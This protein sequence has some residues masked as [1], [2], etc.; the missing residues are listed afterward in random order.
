MRRQERLVVACA[1]GQSKI[2]VLSKSKERNLSGFLSKPEGY[3]RALLFVALM[4]KP[5]GDALS[6]KLL[7]IPSG[8]P[9]LEI[10]S[11]VNSHDFICSKYIITP[12]VRT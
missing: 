10:Y 4:N 9:L 3:H 11:T 2:C 8:D 1:Q 5:K 12:A 6:Y 7:L